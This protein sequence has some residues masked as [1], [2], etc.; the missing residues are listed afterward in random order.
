MREVHRALRLLLVDGRLLD[1][2]DGAPREV[3][4]RCATGARG[5]VETGM[6]PSSAPL[7]KE[8]VAAQGGS[9]R[10]ARRPGVGLRGDGRIRAASVRM[11]LRRGAQ[12]RSSAVGVGSALPSAGPERRSRGQCGACAARSEQRSSGAGAAPSPSCRRTR[13]LRSRSPALRGGGRLLAWRMHCVLRSD[14]PGRALCAQCGLT[15]T[16]AAAVRGAPCLPAMCVVHC[17]AVADA[18]AL[19]LLRLRAAGVPGA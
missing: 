6:G 7:A 18:P 14:G 15:S 13:R 8:R 19:V 10:G 16:S 2:T 5:G 3:R 4:R 17:E 12:R 11:R 9:S 1:R